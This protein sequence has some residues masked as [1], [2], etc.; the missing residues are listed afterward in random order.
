M[1]A[2]VDP[3]MLDPGRA[4]GRCPDAPA[5]LVVVDVPAAG[6]REQERRVE[7]RRD[8]AQGLDDASPQRYAP[9]LAARLLRLLQDTL[10]VDALDAEHARLEVDVVPLEQEGRLNDEGRSPN[11]VHQKLVG[12]RLRRR[13][14]DQR[15]PPRSDREG[16]YDPHRMPTPLRTL[17]AS[18]AR[19]PASIRSSQRLSSRPTRRDSAVLLFGVLGQS[20]APTPSSTRLA[21]GPPK[22]GMTRIST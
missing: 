9:T 4:Q 2:V 14:A 10:R 13:R 22:F 1:A 16:I 20:R 12:R 8:R 21:T 18:P 11:S 19:Q 6:A 17:G 15:R 7:P 5:P 3:A